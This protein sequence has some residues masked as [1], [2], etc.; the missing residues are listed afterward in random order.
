MSNQAICK[1]CKNTAYL[2]GICDFNKSCVEAGGKYLPHC[3]I[4][5]YYYKCSNCGFIFTDYFDRYTIEE[6]KKHIYN[7]EYAEVDPDYDI[8]RPQGN[9]KVISSI[10]SQ[11]KNEIRIM[12]YGGGNGV[13]AS[14]LTQ[15]GLKEVVTYDPFYK[16]FSEKPVGLY[17]LIT[18]FEVIEHVPNPYETF[19]RMVSMLDVENGL[20]L[21][22]T[23]LQ[24]SNIDEVK[25]N[26]W[27]ISPRNGHISIHTSRS[28]SLLLNKLGLNFE[29]A[30]AVTHFA[31]KE[32]PFFARHLFKR[33]TTS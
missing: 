19:E 4:D 28:I 33:R 15:M 5:I 23:L 7:E 25:T 17:N 14:N 22:S 13:F 20:I 3:G 24:P 8:I 26:W 1:C 29:S 32:I 18:S 30:N 11:F 31:F 9:A 10:F 2:Y 12:D 16:E 27:Y 6:F 21:F